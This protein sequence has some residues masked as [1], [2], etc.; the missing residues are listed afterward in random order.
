MLGGRA[1]TLR[2][3][4]PSVVERASGSRRSALALTAHRRAGRHAGLHGARAAA[5]ASAVDARADQFSFCV[6]LYEAL[7]GER[8]FDA[9]SVEDLSD[10]VI[11]GKLREPPAVKDVPGSVREVVLRGLLPER[12]QRFP[13]MNDLIAALAVGAATSPVRASRGR[14]LVAAALVAALLLI[15]AVVIGARIFR[16]TEPDRAAAVAADA[17][18]AEPPVPSA[19][20]LPDVIVNA[21]AVPEAAPRQTR[22]RVKRP[23]AAKPRPAEKAPAQPAGDYTLIEDPWRKEP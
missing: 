5:P 11:R 13:S 19:P 8:P 22:R 14:R 23:A 4:S 9:E 15:A 6:A 17:A 20:V 3:R 7:Y 16:S 2:R 18:V 21:P 1:A 12:D 10:A